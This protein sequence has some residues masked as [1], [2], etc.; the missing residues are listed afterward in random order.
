MNRGK[1]ELLAAKVAGGQSV[2]AAA[3]EIGWKLSQAY[4]AS[5]DAEFKAMV[6][7]LRSEAIQSAVGLLNEGA[8]KAVATLIELL[9]A[10]NEPQVRLNASKAILGALGGITELGELRQRIDA[11]ES[12]SPMRITA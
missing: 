5:G 7:R 3:A 10:E 2:K 4:A 12:R 1:M 9:A 8:C 11:I 6:H